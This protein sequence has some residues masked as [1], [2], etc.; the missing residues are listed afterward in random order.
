MKTVLC[1][2]DSN[3]WGSIP[4]TS[5]DDDR[6]FSEEERWVGVMQADL[7]DAWR[8]I[9]EGLPG[10]TTVIEDPIEGEH[11]S[12]LGHIR[13]CLGSHRPLD[14]VVVMLGT[15][16]CKRRFSLEAEDIAFGVERLLDEIKS[17][18][19]FVK[20]A[21]KVLVVCPP[22]IEVVGIFTTMF[23]GADRKSRELPA[24]LKDVAQ[25]NG[26]DYFDAGS[27]IRSSAVD[28]IHFEAE[29]HVALGHALAKAVK[30]I[31]D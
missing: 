21:R 23:A 7:G 22:P 20:G 17:R 15:N 18:D 11:L 10:R 8:V 25:K 3:T 27:V 29:A 30:A 4:M 28:G 31:A 13:A 19:V 6:R 1:Y 12:G 24:R 9:A 16:D 26:A 5:W 14:L 2:G